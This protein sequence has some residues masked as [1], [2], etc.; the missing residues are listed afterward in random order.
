LGG[1]GVICG[2]AQITCLL[3]ILSIHQ[4]FEN[5]QAVKALAEIAGAFFVCCGGGESA[6]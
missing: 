3:N 6:K 2:E 4:N 1:S 5:R